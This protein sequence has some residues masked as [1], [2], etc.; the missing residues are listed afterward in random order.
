MGQVPRAGQ[1]GGAHGAEGGREERGGGVGEGEAGVRLDDDDD[2]NTKRILL[3]FTVMAFDILLCTGYHIKHDTIWRF[4]LHTCGV[5]LLLLICS[6]E[7]CLPFFF[8]F[9]FFFF[10]YLI[11]LI[12][13]AGG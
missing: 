4:L 6:D 2:D 13:C 5:F 8:L 1:V 7:I 10:I 3:V 12:F 11:S 9:F